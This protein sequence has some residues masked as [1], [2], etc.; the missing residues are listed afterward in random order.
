MR[1][2][3][4]LLPESPLKGVKLPPE[5]LARVPTLDTDTEARLMAASPPWARLP[6]TLA[7]ETGARAG[8]VAPAR[9]RDVDLC[10][11]RLGAKRARGTFP[12]PLQYCYIVCYIVRR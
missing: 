12:P 7:F 4:G 2:D 6:V 1:V 5:A 11:V 3:R 10:V 9:W 8:E